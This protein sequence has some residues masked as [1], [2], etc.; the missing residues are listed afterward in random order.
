MGFGR[1]Y[2]VYITR[3]KI[4]LRCY[5]NPEVVGVYQLHRASRQAIFLLKGVV[6]IAHGACD[7]NALP[8]LASQLPCDQGEGVVLEAHSLRLSQ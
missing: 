8:A 3:D 6:G 4:A 7:Y 2:H 1:G 5:G